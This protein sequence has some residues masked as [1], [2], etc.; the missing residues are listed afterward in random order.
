MAVRFFKI[1]LGRGKL[2][3]YH[4]PENTSGIGK[5]GVYLLKGEAERL[6]VAARLDRITGRNDSFLNQ[7][8][9]CCQEFGSQL[10]VHIILGELLILP[11]ES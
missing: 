6:P 9:F 1:S 7:G 11:P 4:L 3:F 5:H 10:P 8:I 2:Q